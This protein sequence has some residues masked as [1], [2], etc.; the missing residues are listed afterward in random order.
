[1][2]PQKQARFGDLPLNFAEAPGKSSMR[3]VQE[4]GERNIIFAVASAGDKT[5]A[6][7]HGALCDL[8]AIMS[9]DAPA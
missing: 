9:H 6:T 5:A 4:P 1:M 2:R 8:A 7:A 3:S